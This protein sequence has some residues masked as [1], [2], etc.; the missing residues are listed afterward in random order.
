MAFDQRQHARFGPYSELRN[1]LQ[2]VNGQASARIKQQ[3]CLAFSN[4]TAANQSTVAIA[5]LTEDR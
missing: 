4:I 2:R 5:Q 3:A 1:V